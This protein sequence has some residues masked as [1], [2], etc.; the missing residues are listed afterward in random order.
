VIKF[1][2]TDRVIYS[3]SEILI[4]MCQVLIERVLI[5]SATSYDEQ[6]TKSLSSVPLKFSQLSRQ[7]ILEYSLEDDLEYPG[8]KIETRVRRSLK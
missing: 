4:R 7:D 8:G 6:P 1:T 3:L 2:A 5:M